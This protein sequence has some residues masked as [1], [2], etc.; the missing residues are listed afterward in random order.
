MQKGIIVS[1]VLMILSGIAL[2]QVPHLI[3]Y[4]GVLVNPST[5]QPVADDSYSIIFSIYNVPSGGSAIWVETHGV[6]TKDGLYSVILGSITPLTPAILSGPEK[7]LGI[8][9]GADPEMTPRKQIV[10]VAYSYLSE[11][12]AKL[13]GRHAAEFAEADHNHDPRYYTKTELTISDGDPPNQGSNRMSWDNLT[14]MP[15]GFA[16]GVDDPGSGGDNDWTVAGS[17]MYAAVA[18]NV[19]IGVTGPDRKLHIDAS[20]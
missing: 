19:G 17:D 6:E 10:S 9:V 7:Y 3:N 15:P 20:F 18:G 4:Q 5:G 11:D 2:G 14:D 8:K 1:L 12:A 13:E 16:D